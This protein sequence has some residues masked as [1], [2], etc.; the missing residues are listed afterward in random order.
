M[1]K[2]QIEQAASA[3]GSSNPDLSMHCANA[4][5]SV[6]AAKV[7]VEMLTRQHPVPQ[8]LPALNSIISTLEEA[9][10]DLHL[11]QT[12]LRTRPAVVHFFGSTEEAYDR[13]QC[14]EDVK[15]NDVI[16]VVTEQ[17]IGVA[18][19]WPVAVT[20][21]TGKLHVAGPSFTFRDD[22]ERAAYREAI[23]LAYKSSLEVN[24]VLERLMVE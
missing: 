20:T 24:P 14:D 13:T 19:T 21:R 12:V 8:I 5:T 18:G 15:T 7:S 10:K 17:V 16:V 2:D 3:I 1:T 22:E 4:H 9:Q 11:A 6:E 23:L